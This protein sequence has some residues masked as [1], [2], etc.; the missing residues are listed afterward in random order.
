MSI[1]LLPWRE[2][3]KK[4]RQIKHSIQLLLITSII[5]TLALFARSM[6]QHKTAKLP[7]MVPNAK[8]S[9]QIKDIQNQINAEQNQFKQLNKLVKSQ[10]TTNKNLMQIAN[11][12]TILSKVMPNTITLNNIKINKHNILTQGISDNQNSIQRYINLLTNNS[13]HAKVALKQITS[14]SQHRLLFTIR[15]TLT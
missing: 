8:L 10:L 3:A 2:K 9:I 7:L 12:L 1:N 5:F 4:K 14:T 11:L 6:I 15:I 13:T